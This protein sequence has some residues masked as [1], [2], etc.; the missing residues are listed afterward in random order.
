MALKGLGLFMTDN[1][2]DKEIEKKPEQI[3]GLNMGGETMND[4][5]TKTFDQYVL[6]CCSIGDEAL[7]DVFW[8]RTRNPIKSA[9]L[10]GRLCDKLADY[11]H[12]M[13]Q[14]DETWE[15]RYP[16]SEDLIEG[17]T[18][19]SRK[20]NARASRLMA[21]TFATDRMNT[22]RLTAKHLGSDWSVGMAKNGDWRRLLF[23][24]L[25]F[26]DA[27]NEDDDS[28]HE[29]DSDSY[30]HPALRE[31]TDGFW[32]ADKKG[33]EPAHASALNLPVIF[34]IFCVC[35]NLPRVCP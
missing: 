3:F 9:V 33:Y 7:L 5:R 20:Y 32:L 15:E 2:A 29:G 35:P 8:Q 1:A 26:A 6:W 28:T 34:R 19:I 24:Q 16:K 17:M 14:E 11:H 4:V 10:V 25:A 31:N 18:R 30:V 22:G 23:V 13:R 27:G 21:S 12:T